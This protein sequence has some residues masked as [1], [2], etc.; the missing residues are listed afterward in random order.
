MAPTAHVLVYFVTDNGTIIADSIDVDIQGS[1][2]NFVSLIYL[3]YNILNL[4]FFQLDLNSK[5]D[6]KLG[7]EA[8]PGDEI[9]LTVS[10]NPDS[11][12]GLLG[13]DQRSLLLKSGNDISYVCI[14]PNLQ[15]IPQALK[16]KKKIIISFYRNKLSKK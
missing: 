5:V 1:L 3:I 10:T 13:V 9:G 2:Q 6:V 16:F 12:I 4:K 14:F 7:S 15:I 11:Y 8:G